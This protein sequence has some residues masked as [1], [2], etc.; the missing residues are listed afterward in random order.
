MMKIENKIKI[1]DTRKSACGNK[2]LKSN[3][4]MNHP[5]IIQKAAE[6]LD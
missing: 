3:L 5:H 2:L 6:L 4:N 1:V